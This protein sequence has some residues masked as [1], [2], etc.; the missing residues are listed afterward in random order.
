[1][2]ELAEKLRGKRELGGDDKHLALYCLVLG[3]EGVSVL[4]GTKSEERMVRDLLTVEV[5]GELVEAEWKQ[6]WEGWLADFRRA[7]GEV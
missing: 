7:I 6:E 3:L 1:M 5:V 4:N 2:L